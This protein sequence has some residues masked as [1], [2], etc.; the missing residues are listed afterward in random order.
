M[1]VSG[2]V[3][4]MCMINPHQENIYVT[5]TVFLF[6]CDLFSIFSLVRGPFWVTKSAGP[7]AMA[8]LPHLKPPLKGLK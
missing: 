2:P 7:G 6:S 5:E 3:K 1:N 4:W 8:L